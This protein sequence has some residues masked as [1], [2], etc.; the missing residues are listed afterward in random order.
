M[1]NKK[2]IFQL[3]WKLF[4]IIFILFYIFSGNVYLSKCQSKSNLTIFNSLVDSAINNV[5]SDLPGESKYVKLN[6]NLGTEY[7]VFTNEAIGALKKRGIDIS[8]NK[9]PNSIVNTVNLTIEKVN[10][11]YKKMFRKSLLGDFYVPRFFTLSGS[12]SIIGK[13]TFVRKINYSYSDTVNYDHLKNLQNESYPFTES[14][15]PSEPFLSS[16]WEPVIAVGAT[17]VAV[18]LFFT[19]RSK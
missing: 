6:L 5:V 18:V 14:E 4:S 2:L 17:A 16:F 19:I 9:S 1:R 12:Y 13:S 3:K 7:S 10:V 8:E 15:I 11:I